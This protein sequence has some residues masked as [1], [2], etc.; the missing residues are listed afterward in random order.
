MKRTVL[1]TVIGIIL[2]LSWTPFVC[3]GVQYSNDFENPSDSNPQTA[4]PEWVIYEGGSMQAVN[5][6]LEWDTTGGNNDWIRLDH[7]L[8]YE[9]VFEF[10]FFFQE[11]TNGRFSVWPF[12]VPGD[13]IFERYNY[14]LRKNSHFFNGA[15]TIPS[16]GER[17]ITLPVGS[18]PHRLRMEVTGDHVA[19]L[20]KDQGEGG[21]I[22]ID[23]RDFPHVDDP[24]YIQIGYN[25]DGGDAGLI[26]ADNFVLSYRDQNLFNYS[27]NFDNAASE[28]VQASWP[29]WVLLR[30]RFD[31]GR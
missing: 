12:C 5:G 10:D 24:R 17:D 20:Y 26:Y 11:G 13:G 8:P 23:E 6:R 4:W 21:W 29:E 16:E 9:Y 19:F 3:A 18:N 7:E 31:V 15:D 22:L 25:H 1:L 30:R 14:F 27:N 2:C 28:D